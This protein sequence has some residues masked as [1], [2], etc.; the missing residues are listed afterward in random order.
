MVKGWD[1]SANIRHFEGNN[2]SKQ[3]L[4]LLE[5][6][7]WAADFAAAAVA[8]ST[9]LPYSDLPEYG[10]KWIPT[11]WIR[12]EIKASNTEDIAAIKN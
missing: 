7:Y 10:E 6:F 11:G 9:F 12:M 8:S 3:F 2:M 4:L 1:M 5:R